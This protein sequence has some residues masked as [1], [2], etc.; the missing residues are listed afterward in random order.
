[1]TIVAGALLTVAPQAI[2]TLPAPYRDTASA[3]LAA[4]VAM[5]HLYQPSPSQSA[6]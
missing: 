4:L 3:V 5:Y 6:K 2:G 1:M